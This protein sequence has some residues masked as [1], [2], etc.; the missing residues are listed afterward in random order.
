MKKIITSA[1]AVALIAGGATAVIA[2]P[3]SAH[4]PDVACTVDGLSIQLTNYQVKPATTKQVIDVAE[5]QELV[6]EA[7]TEVVE[8][9]PAVPEQP[10]VPAQPAVYGDAPVI[11]PA[12]P[13]QPAVPAVTHVEYQFKQLITGHEKWN[14]DPKWNPG[15]GWYKTGVTKTVTDVP[16]KPA[17]PGQD[18]VLGEPPLITPAVPEQPAVPAVP[19]V[20]H[21]VEHEAEYKTVPATY[22]DEVVPGDDEPNS[23][24]ITTSDEKHTTH[25][26][27]L[28][29]T[30]FS[31][32]I[33]FEDTSVPNTYTVDVTAWDDPERTLGFSTSFTGT[34][35]P[36]TTPTTPPT[37][38]P[39]PPT[40]E[41]TPPVTEQPTPPTEEPTPPAGSPTP[42]VPT[43]TTAPVPPTVPSPAPTVHAAV[44]HPKPSATAAATSADTL[45]YTGFN[46]VA[47][48]FV[49]IGALLA[50]A[51]GAVVL[52]IR[53]RARR[54]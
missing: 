11:T 27:H 35:A 16:A 22:K 5:H 43:P 13:A 41:P 38:E 47:S 33:P 21:T 39:T 30:T 19:A 4:T 3:A 34:C 9:S 1:A 7:W 14:V 46:G 26:D 29:G 51:A 42:S 52:I 24:S 31:K 36:T 18:A 6:K 53:R 10:A 48:V 45:A 23:V 20:T 12:V 8:D 28:F 17:V 15:K 32:T 37:E 49:L 2:G 44:E 50:V 54:A 25:E 40:E